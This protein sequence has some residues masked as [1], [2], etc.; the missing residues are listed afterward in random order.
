MPGNY[1][2]EN[3]QKESLLLSQGVLTGC[4]KKH[5]K[6]LIFTI[7]NSEHRNIGNIEAQKI[8]VTKREEGA[9]EWMQFYNAELHDWY[10]SA[11]TLEVFIYRRMR[12]AGHVAKTE[13]K[14]CRL[15][16]GGNS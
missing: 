16:F 2:K 15:G 13:G 4:A 3:I 6:F 11:I 8:F 14:K 5:V 10:S 9:E 7:Y 1:P 12:L